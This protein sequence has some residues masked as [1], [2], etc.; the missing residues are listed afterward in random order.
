MLERRKIESQEVGQEDEKEVFESSSS[1]N[2]NN[3]KGVQV[4]SSERLKLLLYK[5]KMCRLRKEL[6]I[7]KKELANAR[8]SFANMKNDQ[9]KLNFYTGITKEVFMWILSNVECTTFFKV[10][11]TKEDNLLI[12]LMKLKL[13]IFNKDI[14][15]RFGVKPV[16][17]SKIVRHWLPKLANELKSFIVW[18][19]RD[20]VRKNLPNCFKKFKNCICIIDCTEIFIE[21]PLNLNA[22]TQ[23]WSSY[24]NNNTIK[25]FIGITPAGVVSFLSSGW[26]GRVSDKEITNNCGFLDK[27]LHGDLILA[28]RGFT[29]DHE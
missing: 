13:G 25:Y 1:E 29:I 26:G 8:L 14:A 2:S 28:D 17:I 9:E 15:Y 16:I 22:R 20:V 23:T 3:D 10:R 24:K 12:V 21:R 7:A 27:V 19:E 6:N 5:K 4:G 11:L 18:L